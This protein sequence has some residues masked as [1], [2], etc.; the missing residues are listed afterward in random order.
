MEYL[1]DL[2]DAAIQ[3]LA[4]MDAVL[5]SSPPTNLAALATKKPQRRLKLEPSYLLRLEDPLPTSRDVANNLN[6]PRVSKTEI[7]YSDNSVA[8]FCH[9]DENGAR[10]LHKWTELNFPQKRWTKV[11]LAIAHKGETLQLMG[12][13]PTLP[14]NRPSSVESFGGSYDISGKKYPTEYFFYGT[15]ASSTKL[16]QLLEIPIAEVPVLR[17]AVLQDGHVRVWSNRYLALVESPGEKV[18]GYAFYVGSKEEEDALRRYEGDNYEVVA[19]RLVVGGT[20]VYGRT[21]RFVGCED[22]LSG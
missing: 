20:E 2:E 12:C 22:E 14:Q 13:D 1:D 5:A 4:E 6:L 7:G 16:S 9:L 17:L 3:A 8:K 21:F 10:A 11:R 18:N 15:L 19:A